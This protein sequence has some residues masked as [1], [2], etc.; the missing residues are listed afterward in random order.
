MEKNAGFKIALIAGLIF[1]LSLATEKTLAY[2]DAEEKQKAL[3][4]AWQKQIETIALRG[5]E[6][7][8]N[9]LLEILARAGILWNREDL[10]M[11]RMEVYQAL[12]LLRYTQP[13]PS[14]DLPRASANL[15]YVTKAAIAMRN[16]KSSLDKQD[17]DRLGIWE[18][19]F[20]NW[21]EPHQPFFGTAEHF[22][23][24]YAP[25]WYENDSPALN[26]F[27]EKVL[28]KVPLY[29]DGRVIAGKGHPQL[30]PCI[31]RATL[32]TLAKY[33]A[34]LVGILQEL[35][36]ADK[37]QW[38]AMAERYARRI[39]LKLV[40]LR[41]YIFKTTGKPPNIDIFNIGMFTSDNMPDKE[42]GGWEHIT[43]MFFLMTNPEISPQ[44]N[45][46]DNLAEFM[47][48]YG[49]EL[50]LLPWL[51]SPNP[52]I[53]RATAEKLI[54]HKSF[55]ADMLIPLTV[56]YLY[57]T[58]NAIK[59]VY[60]D[61]FLA[62]LAESYKLD[63]RADKYF[64]Y[65]AGYF[66]PGASDSQTQQLTGLSIPATEIWSGIL[67]SPLGARMEELNKLKEG[68]LAQLLGKTYNPFTARSLLAAL[69]TMPAYGDEL[70]TY[71]EY[72]KQYFGVLQE[73]DPHPFG[74]QL[75][76]L[77]FF[78]YFY[79]K[80][81]CP[82]GRDAQPG[83]IRP[84]LPR[85][86]MDDAFK[87]TIQ[88]P[89]E[90]AMAGYLL[91]VWD[92]EAVP[93]LIQLHSQLDEIPIY[94]EDRDFVASFLAKRD[95]QPADARPPYG[96]ETTC[97]DAKK[98]M[99]R[100]FIGSIS[101]YDSKSKTW[102]L[103]NE[104]ANAKA[105][106]RFLIF[107]WD[108]FHYDLPE[109]IWSDFQSYFYTHY[110]NKAHCQATYWQATSNK[111]PYFSVNV[112]LH[113]DF[114]DN[115]FEAIYNMAGENINPSSLA[116]AYCLY[117]APARI[118]KAEQEKAD[119][120]A[121]YDD[122]ELLPLIG[123]DAASLGSQMREALRKLPEVAQMVASYKKHPLTILTMGR[124]YGLGSTI[125]DLYDERLVLIDR[126]FDLLHIK[127]QTKTVLF[128]Y[129]DVYNVLC[130][131]NST[132]YVT[133]KYALVKM[134]NLL[135][136]GGETERVKAMKRILLKRAVDIGYDPRSKLPIQYGPTR[137][138]KA[139]IFD[140]L[141]KLVS[142]IQYQHTQNPGTQWS[143][144]FIE[145]AE[146]S[147]LVWG[148]WLTSTTRHYSTRYYRY[149]THHPDLKARFDTQ[150][151]RHW[152]PASSLGSVSPYNLIYPER[153]YYTPEQTLQNIWD[154]SLA[155][156]TQYF[157]PEN[158]DKALRYFQL[159]GGKNDALENR[160]RVVTAL[161]LDLAKIAYFHPAPGPA[162]SKPPIGDRV[163][164]LGPESRIKL[165]PESFP[166]LGL[167]GAT[168][169][170]VEFLTFL[171]LKNYDIRGLV[172]EEVKQYIRD[173]YNAFICKDYVRTILN[174]SQPDGNDIG[175][176]KLFLDNHATFFEECNW[177]LKATACVYCERGW[178]ETLQKLQKFF[179]Q[180]YNTDL[181]Y[182]E[183][184]ASRE[185]SG[186]TSLATGKNIRF[187]PAMGESTAT[188]GPGYFPNLN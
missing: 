116:K 175:Y 162:A 168:K 147:T 112:I 77:K 78:Y 28:Q 87:S 184:F 188:C 27:V 45:L 19:F 125:N 126:L 37:G 12:C 13:L 92:A 96:Y 21:T 38:S 35:Y 107:G 119:F 146:L 63:P 58:N 169:E 10:K 76:C 115:A 39:M 99:V 103:K 100:Y 3:N 7:G 72:L 43:N 17:Q 94:W 122:P 14:G 81:F 11:L 93:T 171:F 95:I 110:G 159:P 105:L 89:L 186:G 102:V 135:C 163:R 128:G 143:E 108:Y 180:Y 140:N 129:D 152:S 117:I 75:I 25:S 42:K 46:P 85:D 79:L 24:D 113:S 50:M 69:N 86:D 148:D 48:N 53:R 70:T 51:F 173:K 8:V 18:Y 36:P 138:N 20:R 60:R 120:F 49:Y 22:F 106:L 64:D 136:Y 26:A 161:C 142:L 15:P 23:P 80:Y 185:D 44:N 153:S 47:I 30:L 16:I 6:E 149:I 121:R 139:T 123:K 131:P 133:E 65:L 132:D 101:S 34:Q 174:S 52:D 73:Y 150:N 179:Y 134:A 4:S 40:S 9:Q 151:M 155:T 59:E 178:V 127:E 183:V 114:T 61:A 104:G 57:E 156:L 97:M 182:T 141:A 83:F 172:G 154:A 90:D 62:V 124:T 55:N 118:I 2:T 157:S 82:Q 145:N 181:Y 98:M 88:G 66:F 5:E 187:V 74:K 111:K 160:L 56:L 158:L 68:M 29:A 176:L 164:I 109:F 170:K 67:K 1:L 33:P 177:L 54:E 91:Q 41:D 144:L 167:T 84:S 130:D 137:R 166:S 71:I 31:T 165:N 32:E